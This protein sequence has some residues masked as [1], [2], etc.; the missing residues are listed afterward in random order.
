[1]EFD[2]YDNQKMIL[3]QEEPRG[4]SQ[5]I[6]IVIVAGQTFVPLP[7][8]QQLQTSPDQNIIIKALRLVTLPELSTG[9]VN[10]FANAALTELQKITL[11][12]YCEGWQKGQNIPILAL[13]NTFTEGSGFPFRD[14]TTKLANWKNVD[15]NKSTINF[16]NGTVAVGNYEVILEAEYVRFDING[17]VIVGPNS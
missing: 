5:L 4:P 13:N 7:I 8:I 2:N 10:G 15:W 14:K 17:N 6:E 9:P 12:L 3:I 16:A 1:M 11:T